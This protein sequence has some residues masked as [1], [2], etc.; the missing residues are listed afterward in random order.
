MRRIKHINSDPVPPKLFN[1]TDPSLKI[2]RW[3][4]E[5]PLPVEVNSNPP[6]KSALALSVGRLKPSKVYGRPRALS[7]NALAEN[8]TK[9]VGGRRKSKRSKQSKRKQ[10]RRRK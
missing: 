2:S 6:N 10:T 9:K 7:L 3:N 5:D 1:N 8:G 4:D